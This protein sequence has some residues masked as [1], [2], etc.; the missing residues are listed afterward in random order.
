MK[1]ELRHQLLAATRPPDYCTGG[2]RVGSKNT[3]PWVGVV[4]AREPSA[5]T[6]TRCAAEEA[7]VGC[8]GSEGVCRAD[9]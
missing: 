6:R 7:R 8:R 2:Q 3:A 1:D 4:F 9:K 5:V